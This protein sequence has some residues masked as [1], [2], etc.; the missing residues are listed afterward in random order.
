MGVMYYAE[1]LHL[2]ERARNAY[3]RQCGKSYSFVE[4]QGFFLPVREASIRYRS[5]GRYD[6]LVYIRIGISEWGRAS[7]RFVYEIRDE[8]KEKILS[9]GSTQ[10]AFVTRDGRPCAIPAWFRE[11]C[12]HIRQPEAGEP[13]Y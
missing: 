6:D 13:L 12:S 1:Y 4:E 8:L 10:H 2:F 11:L 7:I 9:T 5:P 3:I